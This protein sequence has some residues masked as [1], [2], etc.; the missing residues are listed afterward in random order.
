M[1]IEKK[2][3][4]PCL[5]LKPAQG[6]KSQ[7]LPE[8]LDFMLIFLLNSSQ[9]LS[10]PKLAFQLSLSQSILEFGSQFKKGGSH[11]NEIQKIF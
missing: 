8:F 4:T 5:P 1:K 3:T 9:E 7:S 2:K 11:A 10:C 6:N